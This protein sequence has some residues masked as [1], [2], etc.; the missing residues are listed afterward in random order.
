MQARKKLRS[1]GAVAMPAVTEAP[2]GLPA[3]LMTGC[4]T[5]ADHHRIGIGGN[6]A[7]AS[8]SSSMVEQ[9]TIRRVRPGRRSA[10]EVESCS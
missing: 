3:T 1:T 2:Q 4:C 6:C 8:F 10:S 7:I 5:D 9:D